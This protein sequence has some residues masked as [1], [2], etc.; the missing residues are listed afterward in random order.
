MCWG[1]SIAGKQKWVD[2]FVHVLDTSTGQEV[3]RL[4]GEVP[5]Q[6]AVFTPDGKGVLAVSKGLAYWPLSD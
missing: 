1:G 4:E 6:S 2:C 5:F 3:C